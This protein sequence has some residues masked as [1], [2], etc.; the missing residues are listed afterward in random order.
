MA[1]V[2]AWG[3]TRARRAVGA[4][5]S[6][7]WHA[8]GAAAVA[9]TL[10]AASSRR[11]RAAADWSP[12]DRIGHEYHARRREFAVDGGVGI[13]A[14]E[15][16][17]DRLAHHVVTHHETALA[18]EHLAERDLIALVRVDLELLPVVPVR[19]ETLEEFAHFE[20]LAE[21]FRVAVTNVLHEPSKHAVQIVHTELAREGSGAGRRAG[22][23]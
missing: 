8:A 1:W 12:S 3:P 13:R 15:L 22:K 19:H 2:L 10:S 20:R 9:A 5:C 16:R 7:N 14:G 18:R 4:E 23:C 21:I 17:A 6:E 11:W